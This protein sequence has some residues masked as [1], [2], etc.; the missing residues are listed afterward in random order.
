MGLKSELDMTFY[1]WAEKRRKQV[2]ICGHTHQPVFMSHTHA[3]LLE[4]QIKAIKKALSVDDNVEEQRLALEA[5]LQTQKT[6]LIRVKKEEGTNIRAGKRRRPCYFNSGCCSFKDGDIT[7][8][9]IV[10][11]RINLVKWSKPIENKKGRKLLEWTHLSSCFA[12]LE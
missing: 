1:N 2:I 12:K 10:D 5:E 9:E 3:D 4:D 6:E 8:I 11:G 7:G